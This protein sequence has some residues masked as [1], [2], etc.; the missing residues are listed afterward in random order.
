M[1]A[2]GGSSSKSGANRW[3]DFAPAGPGT[4][5][6]M[7]LR[8]FWQ[9]VALG[10]EIEAGKAMPIHVMGERFTLFR[11]E[12]GTPHVVGFRCAH[13]SA[14]LSIGWVRGDCIKCMY[15]GWT[16]DGDGKCVERPGERDPGPFAEADIPAYPTHEH[17][18]VIWAYLGD[19]AA[20]P[21]PSF[22]DYAEVGMIENHALDFPSNW[23]QTMENHFDE[24]HIAFVHSFSGSHDN[25]GRRIELP[26]IKV[27]ETDFG[28]VRE[29]RV[30]GGKKRSTLYMMPNIMRILIP[31]F[32]DMESIGGWRDSYIILVPTDDENHRVYLTQNVEVPADQRDA[33]VALQSRFHERIRPGRQEPPHRSH[34]PPVS[35]VAGG[36]DHPGRP[37]SDRRPHPRAPRPHRHRH[38]RHAPGL[39]PRVSRRH[40]RR[41]DQGMERRPSGPRPGVL[42]RSHRRIPRTRTR[43][44]SMTIDMHCHYVPAE[45]AE[46]LRRRRAAPWIEATDDGRER[47][48]MPIGSLAFGPDYIDMDAR[49]EF[50]DR[51]R[52]ARQMI[53]FPGLFGLDSRPADEALPLLSLFNDDLAALCRRHPDRFTGIAA[54]PLADM[55]AAVAELRRGRDLGLIGAILPVNGFESLAE[56]EKLC[57]LFEAGEALGAHFFIHPGRRP[58]QVPEH[59]PPPGTMPYAD[60]VLARQA[61]DVQARVASTMVTLLFSDFLDP[62]PNVSVHVANLGGTLPMV[63]ERMD[64]ATRLR[65][66]EAPV[67]SSQA[68]RLYVDS[69]SLGPRAIEIAVAVFGPDKVMFGTDCPIFRTDWALDGVRAANISEDDRAAILSGNAARLIGRIASDARQ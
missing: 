55:D 19:G 6:G 22:L 32:A 44:S 2:N 43:K 61:L 64:N 33:F 12:P 56:A 40:R 63:I 49:L 60:N 9:P 30:P 26:E 16:F 68:G 24:T 48:H 4:V 42:S 34:G 52:V 21:F 38:R 57:P 53:S 7:Y 3:V 54:L 25:L 15:H 51:H 39:R 8:K 62:Y 36:R 50:M 29:T 14:Q 37:G 58:D 46:A 17:L 23:F 59:E 28:L 5:G 45:M 11:G 20:P 69:A 67:P 66:P 31:A 27:Y 18:G 65:A 35:A 41:A 10:R 47:L 13:R 1:N